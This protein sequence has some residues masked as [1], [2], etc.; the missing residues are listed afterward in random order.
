MALAS[1]KCHSEVCAFSYWVQ[2][3]EDWSGI[4]LILDPL[5]L[6]KLEWAGH[7]EFHLQDIHLRALAP[8]VGPDLKVDANNCRV[9]TIKIY[10]PRTKERRKGW[11]LLFIAYKP[12]VTPRRSSLPPSPHRLPRLSATL[13]TTYLR[14]L[15]ASSEPEPTV[16]GLSPPAGMPCRGF[17]FMTSCV[18]L[19]GIPIWLSLPST[20]W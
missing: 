7:P 18:Q 2:Q 5:S 13:T 12:Q 17:H 1:A 14:T 3:P 9:R 6:V 11:K 20:S 15:C 10:P 4:T 19:S 16:Y 8:F